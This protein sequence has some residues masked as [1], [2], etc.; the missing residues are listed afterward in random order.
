MPSACPAWQTYDASTALSGRDV[1]GETLWVAVISLAS[2]LR[3]KLRLIGQLPNLI[4]YDLRLDARS[5]PEVP[6]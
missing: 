6:N 1:E 2:W 5:Q 4:D 3:C